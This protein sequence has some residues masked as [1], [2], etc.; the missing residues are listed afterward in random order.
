[1]I[2]A[3]GGG[4][5]P[6]GAR[7]A[8]VIGLGMITAVGLGAAET[9][10]AV[11]AGIVGFGETPFRDQRDEPIVMGIVPDEHLP[12]L[13]D[14]VQDRYTFGEREARMLALAGAALAECAEGIEGLETAPVLLAAP[15]PR[16]GRSGGEPAL[17]PQI[18][19]QLALQSG[20]AFDPARGRIFPGGR[21]AGVM[22]VEEALRR[23]ASGDD[24]CV[25]VGGVDSYL[26]EDLLDGL[27]EEGRLRAAGVFDGFVPG[28]GAA[29]LALA[30]PGVGARR[31]R[32][33]LATIAAAAVA[34]EPGHLYSAAPYRGEGLHAAFRALFAGWPGPPVRTVYAGFNGEHLGAKEWGVAYLRSRPRF[35]EGLRIEH[36]IDCLGDPGAALAPIL[37]GLSA[38]GLERGYRRSP[39][40]VFCSSD[41]SLRGAALLHRV[42]VEGAP[43]RGA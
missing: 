41:R 11:R 42:D 40:L 24:A 5:A 2:G 17:G 7:G 35:A 43:A 12:E 9:A 39:C 23:I 6:G 27:D 8:E 37:L 13:S 21:A 20:V 3:A 25:L 22:A 36:P 32:K 30:A 10:R 26:D 1:M 18:F 28:E 38:I 14:E 29:F 4:G 15:E 34:E 19:E 33:P 16:G 31:G